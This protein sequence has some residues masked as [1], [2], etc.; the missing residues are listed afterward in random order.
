V[1]ELIGP[2]VSKRVENDCLH[3]AALIVY[4]KKESFVICLYVRL[5][6]PCRKRGRSDHE[7]GE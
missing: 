1:V 3:Q 4:G 7:D 6:D 2:A 5:L